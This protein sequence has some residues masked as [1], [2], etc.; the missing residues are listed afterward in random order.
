MGTYVTPTGLERKTLQEVRLELETS[1]KEVFGP[2]FE[3]SVDSP[4][5]LLI[6]QIALSFDKLWQIVDE[7]YASRDPAQAEGIALDWAAALSGLTRK[8]E[9]SCR[10]QA[11]LYTESGSSVT[12]PAGSIARRARGSLD[13]SLDS[14]VTIDRGS[15]D[16]LLIYDDGSARYT[17]YVFNFSFGTVTLYNSGAGS[18]MAALVDAVIAGGGVAGFVPGRTDAIYVRDP[19]G[20]VG[21]T[22]QMPSKFKFSAGALGGFTAVDAGAQTCEAGELDTIPSAVDGWDGVYNWAAGVAGTNIETDNELRIRRER[23]VRGIQARGTDEAI[24]AHLLEDVEGVT[25]AKVVSNRTMR[26]DADGRPPKSFEALV[27]GGEDTDVASCIWDSQPSGIQAWGNTAVEIRDGNGDG[28]IVRFSRPV[29]KYLWLK[30]SYTA[31][32]EEEPSSFASVKAAIMDW[33]AEEYTMGKDV[34]PTRVLSG[35]Y[36]VPGIGAAI[37]EASITDTPDGVP[38]Y[39]TWTIPV[40]PAE[41]A[42]LAPTRI[43][44]VRG[45]LNG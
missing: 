40:G 20:A 12:I 26:T 27:V 19:D 30:V 35:L 18:N 23:S 42:A 29:A 2:D 13:F 36:R 15:C 6:S 38:A 43:L 21:I 44:L 25:L 16:E 4:N 41:Y 39:G 45:G 22:G 32:D 33:A 9:T 14:A 8:G 24:A 10:V 31:Y 7:V 34:I 37:V 1:F 11:M 3:T 17:S 28:Q 5:G